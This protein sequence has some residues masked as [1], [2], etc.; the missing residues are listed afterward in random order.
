[1][2]TK[3]LDKN[4]LDEILAAK[5]ASR[6]A[7]KHE[8]RA[9]AVSYNPKTQKLELTLRDSSKLFLDANLIQGLENA[10]PSQ[11]ND[12]QIE[13]NGYGLHWEILDIDISVPGLVKGIYGTKA[14]MKHLGEKGGRIS[15]PLKANAAR[16]NG[17]RGGRPPKNNTMGLIL[18][19]REM[20]KTV[21]VEL[22]DQLIY[23]TTQLAKR[24]GISANQIYQRA[25]ETYLEQHKPS[26]P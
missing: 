21:Q 9:K 3:V 17:K 7:E 14:W 15:N 6:E 5:K 20:K 10:T 1:M 11:I 24:Q 23:A 26:T 12:V 8:P 18:D 22:P 2:T 25:L 4:V 19:T 16:E 13:G